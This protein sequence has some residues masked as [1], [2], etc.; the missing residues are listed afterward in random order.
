M[1]QFYIDGVGKFLF[2]QK[3]AVYPEVPIFVGS[4]KFYRV[5]NAVEF[6][7]ELEYF[8]FSEMKF[9]RNDSAGKVVKYCTE[10]GVHLEYTKFWN[11]D[12]ET[13]QNAKNMTDLK[14]RFK[15]NIAIVGG[16][17]KSVE[18]QKKQEEEEAKKR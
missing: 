1:R 18:K 14:K 16:K 5:K 12:E 3:K 15:Q 8:H 13:F 2:E 10:A 17:G 9:H 6:V 11:K 7:E 4:Y